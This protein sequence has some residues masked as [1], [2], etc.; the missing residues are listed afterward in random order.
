[1]STFE[2]LGLS[3]S[4][5]EAV[6]AIGF[7][8]PT[9]IQEQA[10]PR[11]LSG[12]EDF[13]GLAQT[14]TGKTAAFGLPLL[15][16]TDVALPF[17]QS[18][19]LAPTRELCLQICRELESFSKNQ[20]KLKILPVYGGADIRR[21]IKALEQGVQVLVATPGRLRDLMRRGKVD[22]THL[23]QVVLDEADE[24][25]NMGF[26]EEIDEILEAVPEQRRTWLFSATMPP[27]VRR[28]SQ[29]YMDNPFELSVGT[30]NSGNVD[31]SH[32]YVVLR[33]A[34]RYEALRRFLDMEPDLFGLVFCRTRRETAE[35]A[36]QLTRDGYKADAI[37]GDLNQAQRDRVMQGFRDR[38]LRI[39]VATDVAARGI[40]VDNITHVFH[41]NIPDDLNFYTHRS[42]RT[43]RAGTKGISLVLAH[44][45]DRHLLRKLEKVSKITF[46]AVEI[47]SGPA[48][49]EQRLMR[50]FDKISEASP[51]PELMD[52]LPEIAAKFEGLSREELL[53]RVASATM[54]KKMQAYAK[55]KP[56]GQ[57]PR[58]DKAFLKPNE[59]RR[60][61]V[62]IGQMDI[63]GKGELLAYLC[64]KGGINGADVGKIDLQKKHAFVQVEVQAAASLINKLD[65]QTY[66]GR[67]LRVNDGGP[68]PGQSNKKRRSFPKR[69]KGKKKFAK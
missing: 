49:F 34:E 59:S 66:N 65:G 3:Q 2:S 24:M 38:R 56:I 17:V 9:A 52:Y 47:P 12:E 5:T 36:E 33:P 7:E 63:N 14:G 4:I 45:K 40:D 31:I 1:M 26:K 68:Q 32:Q 60:V 19:V 25:L 50:F 28:I 55:S 37:H 22:Y 15:H 13:V 46:E 21:Q 23:Q 43:G 51:N 67:T 11:L 27:D 35:V 53:L 62:N 29:D 8:S 6:S 61:F 48:I 64:E 44:P 58:A 39:L 69:K 30:Q 57:K 42:G 16:R 20:T 18:L 54:P 10:I 41:F